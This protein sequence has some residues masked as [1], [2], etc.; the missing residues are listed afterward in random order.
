MLNGPHGHGGSPVPRGRPHSGG[1]YG[2]GL[3]RRRGWGRGGYWSSSWPAAYE[4]QAYDDLTIVQNKNGRF[5]VVR[6]G[7]LTALA[8]FDTLAEAQAYIGRT[9]GLFGA[10]GNLSGTVTTSIMVAGAVLAAG[11]LYLTLR[12]K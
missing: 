8:T 4:A 2:G 12:R 10:L 3:H 9:M 11:A 7:S 5:N 1:G 6:V